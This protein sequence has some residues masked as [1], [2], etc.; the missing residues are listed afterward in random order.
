[1]STTTQPEVKKPDPTRDMLYSMLT[2]N[3]G[4]SILDSGGEN[5]R[6]WQVNQGVDFN[7]RPASTLR[8]SV[9]TCH[10]GTVRMDF[11]T[12]Y[13]LYHWLYERL[14]YEP[15]LDRLYQKF[16]QS[17][18]S[19][20]YEL[21]IMKEFPLALRKMR[22]KRH[23]TGLYGSEV[24]EFSS[25]YTYNDEDALS[26]NIQHVYFEIDGE[27]HV[28]LQ[29]HGGADARGGFTDARIFSI[30]N[31]AADLF[32]NTRVTLIGNK[33]KADPSQSVLPGMDDDGPNQII[34][35]SENGG[36]NFRLESGHE[37]YRGKGHPPKLYAD[38]VSLNHRDPTEGFPFST[39][40][41]QRG[42]NVVVVDPDN[43][44]LY[45]PVTGWE[46]T[47]A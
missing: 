40:L 5:G 23:V 46:L 34:W 12:S 9:L 11:E 14:T 35:E 24:K 42:Q 18:R 33:P 47:L 29:V 38:S 30:D 15:K 17:R 32:D 43:H 28:L 13:D 44:K 16:A 36:Y 41:A 1:M 6:M 26:Q 4:R 25:H 8:V 37:L 2:E 7:A 45:C 3:T 31:D 19:E 39:D 27:P 10:D 21:D 22:R 20:D